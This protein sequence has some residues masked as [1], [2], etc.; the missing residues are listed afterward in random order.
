[1]TQAGWHLADELGF[2]SSLRIFTSTLT[3]RSY[4]SAPVSPLFLFGRMQDFTYQQEVEGSP[5][6]RHHVRFW[7]TPEG[8]FL[9]G[10]AQSDWLAAG[11]YDRGVGVS[12]YTLQ[13]T[14]RIERNVDEERD[15]IVRT[16]AEGNLPARV[17]VIRNFSSG[18]HSRNGGG[19]TITTDGDLPI[20]D[21]TQV[22][23]G[24]HPLPADPAKAAL[25][26][27]PREVLRRV[28]DTAA[29]NR[30]KRPMTLYLGTVLMVLRALTAGAAALAGLLGGFG[31]LVLGDAVPI[32]DE[33]TVGLSLV[34]AV[35]VAY[36]AVAALTF[37]GYPVARFAAL[38]VSVAAIAVELAAAPPAASDLASRLLIANLALDIGIL[39]TL[40]SGDVRDF[41]LRAAAHRRS[42]R[43]R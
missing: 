32:A 33:T 36:L 20:V 5:A 17:T 25:P 4:P 24:R 21:L 12:G 39:I 18:F 15:H 40:S 19:D 7:H 9:P 35:A 31:R 10:G 8:W 14:H 37:R 41:V 1:M 2:R 11:T 3:R 43:R 29:S 23:A 16:L 13:I 30:A 38:C 34:L 6:R 26:K 42:A 27:R 22:P 28:K